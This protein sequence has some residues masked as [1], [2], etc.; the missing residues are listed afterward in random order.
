[1]YKS[2]LQP[3]LFL[4]DAEKA[5]HLTTG[6]LKALLKIPGAKSVSK[7]VFSFS[8]Q[9][10]EKE[11]FGLKFKNPIGLAAGFDKNAEFIHEL[12]TFGFGFIEIGT[13]TPLAQP[14]NP[15]PRLFRLKKDFALINRL[16]FNNLGMEEAIRR[17]KNRPKDLIIGGNIGKNK[18][19][20]N[21]EAYRD[22]EICLEGLYPYV[23]YFVVNVS[24]PNTPD[25]RALQEKE[26][27]LN[28][29][30]RL[31]TRMAEKIKEKPILLKIAPDLNSDQI[32]DIV[33]IV[34]ETGISGM[35]VSNTT[36]SRDGLKSD[37]NLIQEKGGLSGKPLSEKST[38]I[39]KEI[40]N[41]LPDLPLIG[42][43]G[44]S[45]YESAKAKLDA[46]ADL[47]QMYTGFVYEGPAIVK[48][49]NKAILKEK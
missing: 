16:G 1:M 37:K 36:I 43:G 5:H 46:G 12:S 11:V 23:D 48:R 38:E 7:S 32:N 24:S 35:I 40:K 22:Y 41:K 9:G 19:T 27:L 2:I 30:S 10:L 28:L 25:L 29:L 42:V 14:G 47:V 21:E 45:D 33:D 13:V 44:I 26:P 17:L 31:K 4:I 39:I 6:L 34:L 18:S 8:D 3:I 15:K 49:I 20:P